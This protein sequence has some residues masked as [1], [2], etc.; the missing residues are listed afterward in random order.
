MHVGRTGSRDWTGAAPA[1]AMEVAA[2]YISDGKLPPR[3]ILRGHR[4]IIDDSGAKLSYTRAIMLP[5]WQLRT[6]YGHRVTQRKRSD[7]GGFI[8]DTAAPDFPILT[9]MRYTAPGGFINIEVV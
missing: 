1:L 4:H 2:D 6:N 7:I 5:S 9:R 3:Y 8:L